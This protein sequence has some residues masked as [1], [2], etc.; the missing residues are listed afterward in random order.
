MTS[1]TI[2]RVVWDVAGNGFCD[3]ESGSVEHGA[4]H[5][6]I[7]GKRFAFILTE[8]DQGFRSVDVFPLAKYQE[9]W[10]LIVSDDV[11]AAGPQDDDYI[12]S[13]DESEIYYH[14]KV[15]GTRNSDEDRDTFI[16]R[17][18]EE[19]Q[20]WPNVWSISDHGNACLLRF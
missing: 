16:G 15:V 17:V 10:N 1:E 12:L 8:D 19:N 7:V 14:N 2:E 11:E 3:E 6:L 4:W 20:Y 9:A 5:G 18:C 13:D